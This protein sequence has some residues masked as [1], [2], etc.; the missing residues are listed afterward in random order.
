MDE[1]IQQA[2]D[3]ALEILHPSRRDLEHGLELRNAVV[4]ESYSLGLRAAVDS[5][6]VPTAT[7][8]R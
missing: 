4:C 6:A 5:E 1:T 2:R 8:S 7:L 3:V